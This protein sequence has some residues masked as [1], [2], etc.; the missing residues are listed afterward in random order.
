MDD[1]PPGMSDDDAWDQL[2]L[3]DAWGEFLRNG[4]DANLWPPRFDEFFNQPWKA[5]WAPGAEQKQLEWDQHQR[6]N[7]RAEQ[8]HEDLMFKLWEEES[9]E[10]CFRY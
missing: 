2:E 8:E 5:P 1:K 6:D 9:I 7:A 10:G 4:P 3:D